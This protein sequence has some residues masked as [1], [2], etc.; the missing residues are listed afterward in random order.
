MGKQTAESQNHERESGLKLLRTL[1]D[2]IHLDLHLAGMEAREEWAKLE[3]K[4]AELSR[5]GAAFGV[6]SHRAARQ[7]LASARRLLRVA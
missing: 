7:L 4:M 5:H 6:A 1:R 2:E 3:P